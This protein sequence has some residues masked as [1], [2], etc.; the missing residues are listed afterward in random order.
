MCL[1]EFFSLFQVMCKLFHFIE[2]VSYSSSIATLI[3][4]A[5]ERYIIILHPIKMKKFITKTRL[6]IAIAAIWIFALIWSIPHLVVFTLITISEG[7]SFCLYSNDK[8]DIRT[9]VTVTFSLLYITPL[10]IM[11]YLYT[12]ICVNLWW[13]CKQHRRLSSYT[14]GRSVSSSSQSREEHN[15]LKPASVEVPV[16]I[17]ALCKDTGPAVFGKKTDVISHVAAITG[18]MNRRCSLMDYVQNAIKARRTP[19]NDQMALIVRRKVIR[20]LLAI[21]IT[22]TLC[23][24]PYHFRVIWQFHGYPLQT[25][26]TICIPLFSQISFILYFLN[27]GLNPFLYAFLSKNFRNSVADVMCCRHRH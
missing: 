23:I 1:T 8:I 5:F 17:S 4:I 25:N 16:D 20:L 22:F 14:Y 21:V 7:T 19:P 3:L 27:S 18:P 26:F 13:T 12:R 11:G 24:T 9:Y 2:A 15:S 6:I 10:C